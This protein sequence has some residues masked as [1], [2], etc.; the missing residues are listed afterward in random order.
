MF[1]LVFVFFFLLLPV[2]LLVFVCVCVP[3]IRWCRMSK[4][5]ECFGTESLE[6]N[7]QKVET[8]ESK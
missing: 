6:T 8:A 7:S 3:D 2:L 5:S 1:H 4:V